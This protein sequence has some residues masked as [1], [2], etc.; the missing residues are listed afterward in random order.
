MIKEDL[1]EKHRI[2]RNVLYSLVIILLITQIS[3]FVIIGLQVSKVNTVLETTKNDLSKKIDSSLD[4]YNLQNQEKFNQIT[5]TLSSQKNSFDYFQK[6][7][8]LLKSTNGDFSGI[9]EDSVLS[10]V[11][12]TTDRAA[13]SGFI[14]SKSGFVVTNEHVINNAGKIRVMTFDREVYN[15]ELIGYDKLRDVA[16][17]KMNGNFNYLELADSD[18]LQIG[19]KVIALGNPLGLSFSATEGIISGLKRIG[20]NNLN[21]YIQT[22]VSLNPGNSGGPLIDTSGRVVGINNFKIGGT[23]GLGFAL[24]SNAVKVSINK[25]ANQTIIG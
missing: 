11:S 24:E 10:V 18:E 5:E 1:H 4:E 21:E 13:G 2:H 20:P 22:D 19:R 17:L 8:D 7:V 3:S 23:E 14:I 9:I 12:V 6:E 16:L 15:A 25:I